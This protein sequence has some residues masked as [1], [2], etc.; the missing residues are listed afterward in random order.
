MDSLDIADQIVQQLEPR[1]QNL[2]DGFFDSFYFTKTGNNL[3]HPWTW[4]ILTHILWDL[5]GIARVGVDV[6]LNSD[7]VK[8]QPDLTGYSI[9]DQPVIFLDYESPNSSDAR[10]PEKDVDPYLA[11]R[12]HCH[13]DV[14]YVIVTTL[15]EHASPNW[16]L[17]YT[18]AG[19]Y[20]YGFRGKREL[21]RKNPCQFWYDFYLTEFT[22][23]DM[24]GISLLNISQKS[25]KRKYPK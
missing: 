14:P 25:I 15:P 17:R 1:I 20:N 4:G 22:N 13:S 5:P 9:N 6:R 12:R 10:I 18:S 24:A 8:F 19:K 2:P 16:E 3:T 11:W 7:G 21:I 23:R